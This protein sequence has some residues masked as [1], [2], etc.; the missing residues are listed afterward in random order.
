VLDGFAILRAAD[1]SEPPDPVPSWWDGYVTDPDW[2]AHGG[3]AGESPNHDHRVAWAGRRVTLTV[4]RL[5]NK[6]DSLTAPISIDEHTERPTFEA[7]RHSLR[8]LC[9]WLESPGDL[10]LRYGVIPEQR[11]LDEAPEGDHE[12]LRSARVEWRRQMTRWRLGESEVRKLLRMLTSRR[13]RLAPTDL[14]HSIDDF[15]RAVS[16]YIK[17]KQIGC[18]RVHTPCAPGSPAEA[19]MLDDLETQHER[20]MDARDAI[21]TLGPKL[22]ELLVRE[23][24]DAQDVYKFLHFITE[25]GGPERGVQMWPDVKA[26]LRQIRC[27]LSGTPFAPA[28]AYLDAAGSVLWTYLD[29]LTDSGES[30]TGGR[31]AAEHLLKIE[32]GALRA[33]A[34]KAAPESMRPRLCNALEEVE[35][36]AWDLWRAIDG[37]KRSELMAGRKAI[38]GP[39][40]DVLDRLNKAIER[41]RCCVFSELDALGS[42]TCGRAGSERT[43]GELRDADGYV[44]A[45]ADESAYVPATEILNKH[46]PREVQI[47]TYKQLKRILDNA[48]SRVRQWRP[49]PQR[50][51]VHLADWATICQPP[52]DGWAEAVDEDL[53]AQFRLPCPAEAARSVT[54]KYAATSGGTSQFRGKSS[55]IDGL[56]RL[57]TRIAAGETR[58]VG[59]ELKRGK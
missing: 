41:A 1:R 55:E 33:A 31:W 32:L 37:R 47:K 14:P 53:L 27:G 3:V 38:K 10:R 6:W 5:L 25:G 39:W 16:D 28:F 30:V 8:N 54:G 51:K 23:K 7:C 49:R 40:S 50:L 15:I 18:L 36:A 24:H 58:E 46:I 4:K 21:R 17:W 26:R 52:G 19:S 11:H 35:Q 44:T 12:P 57:A 29:G 59:A 2:I 9:G 20:E 43:A 13:Y 34:E 45:P 22:T 42:S 48:R 56:V